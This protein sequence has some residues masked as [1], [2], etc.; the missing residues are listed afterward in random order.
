[1]LCTLTIATLT[2]AEKITGNFRRTKV[3]AETSASNMGVKPGR[4]NEKD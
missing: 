1:M 3:I 2:A 4:L